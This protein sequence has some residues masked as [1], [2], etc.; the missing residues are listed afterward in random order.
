MWFRKAGQSAG[1]RS[2][3]V[4]EVAG[5]GLGSS[6]WD[7]DGTG[8]RALSSGAGGPGPSSLRCPLLLLPPAW[9]PCPRG[10][11]SWLAGSRLDVEDVCQPQ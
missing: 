3:G 7:K 9:V 6:S 11:V 10:P 4:R 1:V 8:S 2:R 5:G